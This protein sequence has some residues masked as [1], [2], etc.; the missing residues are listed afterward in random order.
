MEEFIF[1]SIVIG[2]VIY[3]SVVYW[4]ITL[5]IIVIVVIYFLMIKYRD[6]EEARKRKQKEYES[7]QLEIKSKTQELVSEPKIM[8]SRIPNHIQN[9][10]KNLD[11]AEFE[12]RER[13]FAP[14][15]DAVENAIN[16]LGRFY[17]SVDQIV[18]NSK[19]HA[20]LIA[21]FDGEKSTFS[22]SANNSPDARK[23]AERMRQL[24][25]QAQKDFQFATIYEQRK[26]NQILVAGFGNLADTINNMTYRIEASI[27]SL[28]DVISISFENQNELF[29]EQIVSIGME[30][31]ERRK[32]E[33]KEREMLDNIQRRKKPVP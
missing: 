11:E 15:W 7:K 5:S 8:V 30:G 17:Q 23:T 20:K 29:R 16:N 28:S 31:N 3:F 14:F 25:R 12:F 18:V 6:D 10:E 1:W 9:A 13:A 4:P 27:N 21:K 19:T 22:V 24:V 26:T 2:V 33:E 32:H